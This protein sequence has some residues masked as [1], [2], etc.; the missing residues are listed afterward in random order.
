MEKTAFSTNKV[1]GTLADGAPKPDGELFVIQ[2]NTTRNKTP[3]R[4]LSDAELDRALTELKE[5]TQK[6]VFVMNSMI[7]RYGMMSQVLAAL[8]FE[9]ER[10]AKGVAIAHQVPA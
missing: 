10:R 7:E 8:A 9:Q 4:E 6:H 1:N 2:H 3:V 5:Q